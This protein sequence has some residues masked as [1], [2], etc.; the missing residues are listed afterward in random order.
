MARL[1]GVLVLVLV[2][3]GGKAAAP[4]ATV[5]PPVAS[6]GP[7]GTAAPGDAEEATGDARQAGLGFVLLTEATLPSPQAIADAHAALAPD[8]PPLTVD[9]PSDSGTVAFTQD[10]VPVVVGLMP[11]AVPN[12][13]AEDHARFSVKGILGWRPPA[14]TA[15]LMVM[16]LGGKDATPLERTRRLHRVIAA[17]AKAAGATAVGVYIGNGGV[18]HEPAFYIDVVGGTPD[19]MLAWSGVSVARDASGRVSLLSTG[20]G[21][22]GLPDILITTSQ[23]APGEALGTLFDV[24]LYVA[25]RGERLPA[26]HTVGSKSA[27]RY[28]VRYAPSPVDPDTEVMQVDYP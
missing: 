18:T 11:M 24:M 2:G 28:P 27:E 8:G 19:A 15:H 22:L 5:D 23:M 3:C 1:L 10:G 4:A 13:E 26:G 20:M 14:H 7:P 21:Q 17:T 6:A 25:R 12:N 16:H 9:G